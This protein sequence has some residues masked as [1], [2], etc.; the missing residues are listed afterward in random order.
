MLVEHS[1]STGLERKIIRKKYEKGSSGN[2]GFRECFSSIHPHKP[3]QQLI[4]IKYMM[5][6]MMIHYLS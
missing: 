3:D 4:G 5:L 6:M 2:T 1:S